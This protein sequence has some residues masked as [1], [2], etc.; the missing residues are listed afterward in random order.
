[1]ITDDKLEQLHEHLESGN[2]VYLALHTKDGSEIGWGNYSRKEVSLTLKRGEYI[3]T[4]PI[5]FVRD[6]EPVPTPPWWHIFK[7]YTAGVVVV[8]HMSFWTEQSKGEG[9]YVTCLSRPTNIGPQD[10]IRFGTETINFS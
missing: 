6:D 10:T 4:H 9:L 2:P 7:M 1:M 8:T 3:S 5:E